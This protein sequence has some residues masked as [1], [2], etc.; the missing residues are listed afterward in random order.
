MNENERLS[1]HRRAQLSSEITTTTMT[2]TTKG[3]IYK[4]DRWSRYR[5]ENSRSNE[6]QNLVGID[7]KRE[8]LLRILA[9]VVAQQQFQLIIPSHG[10][11][12]VPGKRGM[13]DSRRRRRRRR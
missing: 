7:P 10:R 9:L 11:K 12:L 5:R 2:T 4:D 3:T 6:F 13:K 8:L 1:P